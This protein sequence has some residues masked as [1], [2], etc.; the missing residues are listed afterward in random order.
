MGIMIVAA[1]VLVAGSAE[2]FAVQAVQAPVPHAAPA[3][4]PVTLLSYNVEGLPW[5]LTH[6]R[7]GA[8]AAIAAELR[9]LHESGAAPQ[10][11]A[12][13]EAFGDA[14]KG[15]GR[16][17]GYRYTVYGPDAAMPRAAAVTAADQAFVADASLWH[18]ETEAPR[19]DS[20]LAI[21]SDYPVLW[22]RRVPFPAFACAGYDCL[23]NKGMLA[24]ALRLPGQ[25]KPLIVIDTHLNAR[26][27]SGVGDAR[28]LF[29][30][31]RQVAALRAFVISLERDG[32]AVV[33]AGDFNV[34]NDAARQRVLAQGLIGNDGLTV[35]ASESACGSGCRNLAAVP[36]IA[37]AKT[38]LA[39][40]GRLGAT[41][42][43]VSFGTAPDGSQLSDHI[44]V[45]RTFAPA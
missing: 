42:L 15:I 2:P 3:A 16:A 44:G 5:P 1:I 35:A 39:Y 8:A 4:G 6:G 41:G 34:G 36:G 21:F 22:A 29:A 27:A 11:V 31:A 26:T 18:G 17:A 25:A 9:S 14:Q 37:H 20:G 24:V 40:R 23:A 45:M 19:E 28:S 43:P 12:V 32:S 13:Q 38:I 33:L 10:V 30:Y 7:T